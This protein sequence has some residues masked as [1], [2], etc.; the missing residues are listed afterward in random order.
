MF[1]LIIVG[2]SVSLYFLAGIGF[3]KMVSKIKSREISVIEILSWPIGILV[4]AAVGDIA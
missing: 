1:E 2:V 4:Y 3:T